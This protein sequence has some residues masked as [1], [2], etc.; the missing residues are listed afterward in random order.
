[1]FR[2]DQVT[3]GVY[4]TANMPLIKPAVTKRDTVLVI[5]ICMCLTR[6]GVFN[7]VAL[8]DVVVRKEQL[9]HFGY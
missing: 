3:F 1:M 5:D 7:F 4:L 2:R 6:H 8:F 9:P